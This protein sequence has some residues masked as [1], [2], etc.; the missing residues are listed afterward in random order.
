MIT[1]SV[2]KMIS[3]VRPD[4]IRLSKTR[5]EQI[6]A[7]IGMVMVQVFNTDYPMVA[8]E[9]PENTVPTEKFEPWDLERYLTDSNYPDLNKGL[10]RRN[11]EMAIF[12]QNE[13]LEGWNYIDA[14]HAALAMQETGYKIFWT[15]KKEN[16]IFHIYAK[17][18]APAYHVNREGNWYGHLRLL[19]GDVVVNWDY[20]IDGENVTFKPEIRDSGNHP[21]W[22]PTAEALITAAGAKPIT[23]RLNEKTVT[24]PAPDWTQAGDGQIFT[25]LVPFSEAQAAAQKF[26]RQLAAMGLLG[27]PQASYVKLAEDVLRLPLGVPFAGFTEAEYQL[28]QGMASGE[29]LV[30]R[31]PVA[32]QTL[33]TM[34][35]EINPIQARAWLEQP[36]GVIREVAARALQNE[37]GEAW[38]KYLS[39]LLQ[40]ADEIGLNEH[41]LLEL[42]LEDVI[43]L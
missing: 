40:L 16:G 22:G 23:K 26:V 38:G 17:E 14:A 27:E 36:I 41:Q 35:M 25:D 10:Y 9:Q 29:L 39:H 8:K 4:D 21:V 6:L 32:L 34:A 19:A 1:K 30:V 11:G 2:R 42:R 5:V 31:R 33:K 20:T 13:V 7:D 15:L 28:F 37:N 3:A 24:M 43:S 18:Q 12:L